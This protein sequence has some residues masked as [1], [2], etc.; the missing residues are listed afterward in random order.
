MKLRESA[1]SHSVY[2]LYSDLLFNLVIIFLV[3]VLALVLRVNQSMRHLAAQEQALKPPASMDAL[4]REKNEAVESSVQLFADLKKA[5]TAVVAAKADNDRNRAEM[6][7]KLNAAQETLAKL[8]AENNQ[9]N[10][11]LSR[12]L[13][14]AAG[15]NRFT[16]RTGM[17]SLCV[18]IDL[19]GSKPEYVLIDSSTFSSAHSQLNGESD[20]EHLTR[21]A[22]LLTGATRSAARYTLDELGILFRSLDV[23]I[24]ND[25]TKKDG[26][27]Q[28]SFS[29]RATAAASGWMNADGDIDG[30]LAHK[31]IEAL[32]SDGSLERLQ[33]KLIG[34]LIKSRNRLRTGSD[35]ESIPVLHFSVGHDHQHIKLGGE[36][37]DTVRFCEMARAFGDGGVILQYDGAAGEVCPEWVIR[38]VLTRVGYTNS[39][40]N[41]DE[42]KRLQIELNR[43]NLSGH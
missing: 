42:L 36:E 41:N 3:F 9:R 19:S 39:V 20:A 8:A 25:E 12:K 30:T 23:R 14:I 10:K 32:A 18:G 2:V 38:D 5:Q 24:A 27:L 34:E 31:Q 7:T 22:K 6:T 4:N 35:P 21:S 26:Q 33:D 11:E 28:F 15:A 43:D 1:D 37:V 16:G 13:A 29:S 17:T 40:P